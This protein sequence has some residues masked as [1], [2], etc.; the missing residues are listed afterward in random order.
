MKGY[1]NGKEA[2]MLRD[3]GC[4]TVCISKKFAKQIN[5]KKQEKKWVSLANGTECLCYKVEVDIESL[6]IS[7]TVTALTMDCP[8]ADVILGESAFVKECSINYQFKIES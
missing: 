6:Y 3:T 8:F 1:V 4:T 2:W 5:S 7:G